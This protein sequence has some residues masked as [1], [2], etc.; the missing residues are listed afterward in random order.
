MKDEHRAGGWWHVG[1]LGVSVVTGLVGVVDVGPAA[2]SRTGPALLVFVVCWFAFGR[3]TFRRRRGWQA[4][5]AVVVAVCFVGAWTDPGFAIFQGLAFPLVWVVVDDIRPSIVANV[6]VAAA[7]GT[8][9][10]LFTHVLVQT[11]FVEGLSLAMSLALGLW[12][13]QISDLS[14][15]RRRLLEELSAAQETVA[16]LNVDRGAAAERERLARELHDTIAQS[17]TGIVMMAERARR[18][19]PADP[20][21]DVLEESAREAL[22]ETRGLVAASASVG[23]DGGLAAAFRL[24]GERFERETGVTVTTEVRVDVPRGLEVVLLRCAQEGLANVRK[25]ATASRADV[26]LEETDGVV[27]L[28]VIDDG[29]GPGS[30]SADAGFGLAGMRDRLALVDGDVVLRAGEHGGATLEVRIALPVGQTS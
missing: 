12:I 11:L 21:L 30:A 15:Q 22:A 5:V 24:L 27:R 1:V 13:S 16:A 4:F 23:L 10:F 19:Y 7:I 26:H 3:R 9:Y 8:G 28:T 29:V 20:Q 14:E 2:L 6:L 17:L 25:H 18:R